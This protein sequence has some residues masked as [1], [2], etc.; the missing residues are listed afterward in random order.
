[1]H[2]KSIGSSNKNSSSSMAQRAKNTAKYTISS[3]FWQWIVS[4]TRKNTMCRYHCCLICSLFVVMVCIRTIYIRQSDIT[5]WKNNTDTVVIKANKFHLLLLSSSFPFYIYFL[6]VYLGS[7]LVRCFLHSFTHSLSHPHFN[8]SISFLL[9]YYSGV[10]SLLQIDANKHFVYSS[11]E[12]TAN[13]FVHRI[14]IV[15]CCVHF[16]FENWEI[17]CKEWAHIDMYVY[18]F[19][20]ATFEH[21][22]DTILAEIHSHKLPQ[23]DRKVSDIELLNVGSCRGCVCVCERETHWAS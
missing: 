15:F 5:R 21:V 11:I 12:S 6:V 23:S 20:F 22:Y 14:K 17:I 16:G 4:H 1:M 9:S 7:F 8:L 13:R 2:I 19:D 3:I 18:I 10:L